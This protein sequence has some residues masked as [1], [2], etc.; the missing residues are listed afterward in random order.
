MARSIPSTRGAA[1]PGAADDAEVSGAL[2]AVPSH[3]Y[4]DGAWYDAEYVHMQ[5]DVPYYRR[6]ARESPGP[7]LELACGTGRLSFPMAEEGRSVVGVD[8]AAS[9]LERAEAKRRVLAP[10]AQARLRFEHADLRTLRLGQRFPTVVL[11]FNT[12]MHMLSDEDLEAALATVQ[13]HLE[14][15]GAF[16]L[17]LYTPLGG[18]GY[19]RDPDGRYDPQQLIDPHSGQRFIVT[20][21]SRYDPRQQLNHASFYYRQADALGEPIGPEREVKVVLRVIYPRELDYWFRVAGFKIVGD[22][23]DFERRQPFRGAGGRRVIVAKRL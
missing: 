5:A 19:V 2:A 14:E 23:E 21:N 11:A 8:S 20:E 13:A 3:H 4:A 12:L 7:I 18:T 17:D 6:V 22:W 15:D 10:E 1:G 9:M 16:H